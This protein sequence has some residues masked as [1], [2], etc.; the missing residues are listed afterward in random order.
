MLGEIARKPVTAKNI[1]ALI[2]GESP[3]N[4]GC[5][6]ISKVVAPVRGIPIKGPISQMMINASMVIIFLLT[7]FPISVKLCPI[8]TTAIKLING[9]IIPVVI[10]PTMA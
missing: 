2:I 3:G 5:N 8:C 7:R 1:T 4:M 6:H 10:N 9:A